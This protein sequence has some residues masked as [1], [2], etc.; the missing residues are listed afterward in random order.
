MDVCG[1]A[2]CHNKTTPR[3]TENHLERLVVRTIIFLACLTTISYCCCCSGSCSTSKWGILPDTHTDERNAACVVVVSALAFDCCFPRTLRMAPPQVDDDCKRRRRRSP[4]LLLLMGSAV[5]VD[6][7]DNDVSLTNKSTAARPGRRQQ[8]KDKEEA[9]ERSGKRVKRDRS[10]ETA[11]AAAAVG[12]APKRNGIKQRTAAA[13]NADASNNT[14]AAGPSAKPN[15]ASI[16]KSSS[17]LPRTLEM[18]ARNQSSTLQ[19]V[20]GVDEAGRGPL[21][22]PVCAAAVCFGRD[23]DDDNNNMI[24]IEGIV[25]SKKITNEADREALY[26]Q[27]VEG[28]D[29]TAT[30][31]T[32]AIRWA[33]AVMDVPTIDTVNILQATLLGMKAATCAVLGHPQSY[34]VVLHTAPADVAGAAHVSPRSGCYVVTNNAVLSS[35]S[36]LSSSSSSSSEKSSHAINN[37]T[38]SRCFDSDSL[39]LIDGNKIPGD[40]PCP[41]EAVVRGDGREYVI[42]MASILAKVTRDRLMRAYHELYPAYNLSRHKGYG[43]AAHM[44]AIRLHGAT[45]IHRRSFAPLKHMIQLD[46]KARRDAD[47][48]ALGEFGQG[49][50]SKN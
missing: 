49:D 16:A 47:S 30:T 20:I 13:R 18:Q 9:S 32:T 14:A 10:R 50:G 42:A 29:A 38:K 6:H 27:I 37:D 48:E 2:A 12:P 35:A 26:R 25:D 45:P 11:A 39:A 44:G 4:R 22:G 5:G 23:D 21:A 24:A 31:T 15:K 43:T 3:T 40:M 19:R 7:A 41:A 17:S 1:A 28:H 33:V 34:P 8:R 36:S 46:T